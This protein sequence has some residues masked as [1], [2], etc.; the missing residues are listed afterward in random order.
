MLLLMSAAASAATQ[1]TSA[2]LRGRG[3]PIPLFRAS[4]LE[5]SPETQKL[6]IGMLAARMAVAATARQG[7]VA[8][9]GRAPASATRRSFVDSNSFIIG[10]V[11]DPFGAS[12]GGEASR[13]H[14]L[15]PQGTIRSSLPPNSPFFFNL[16][17]HFRSKECGAVGSFETNSSCMRSQRL[18]GSGEPTCGHG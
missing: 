6:G 13:P 9:V 11:D 5:I 8:A 7:D 10:A 16:H 17:K 12:E 15:T 1:S 14:D 18:R 2:A 4:K 3:A